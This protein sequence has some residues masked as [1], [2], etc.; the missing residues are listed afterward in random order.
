MDTPDKILKANPDHVQFSI[1]LD[2]KG[3][4]DEFNDNRG[5]AL[6]VENTWQEKEKEHNKTYGDLSENFGRQ[7]NYIN[8]QK[9]DHIIYGIGENQFGYRFLEVKNNIPNAYFLGLSKF[10]HLNDQQ[11]ESFVSGN[12]ISAYGS[13][14]RIKESWGYPF[15]PQ[16]E[17]VKD[18]LLFE[19]DLTTVRK[20]SDYDRFNDLFERLILLNPNSADTDHDR[21]SDFTDINPLY[22]S[23]KSKFTDLYSQ[24]VDNNYQNFNFS[25]NHYS[26]TG[27]FSDCDYFHKIN[28]GNVKV[29]IYPEKERYHID[30]DYGLNRFPENIGK[31]E[32]DKDGKTFRIN[33]GSGAGGGFVEAIY[34]NGKW[35]LS[36]QSTYII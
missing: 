6:K 19:I 2:I 1:D 12:K 36:E 21:I 11:P 16:L 7:F 3:Y 22:T 33:Y 29:L 28:P 10:T 34:E 26:F 32:K 14:I 5:T 23:E 25:K 35:V 30:S 8:I 17:A 4:E 27:Y 9:K 15:G 20:D 24:I 31:I 13:F 18:Q